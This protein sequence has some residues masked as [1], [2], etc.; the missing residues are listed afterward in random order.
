[1]DGGCGDENPFFDRKPELNLIEVDSQ[2]L[3]EKLGKSIKSTWFTDSRTTLQGGFW[4]P[5]ITIDRNIEN[6]LGYQACQDI[7]NMC[8][9]LQVHVSKQSYSSFFLSHHDLFSS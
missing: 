3:E 4:Q 5:N 9:G 6:S 8:D 2:V 7:K 1:M